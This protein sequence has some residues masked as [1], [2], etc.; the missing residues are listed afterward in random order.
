MAERTRANNYIN[1]NKLIHVR[2]RASRKTIK[3]DIVLDTY[4]NGLVK[5]RVRINN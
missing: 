4:D 5:T 1:N 2:L 3:Y